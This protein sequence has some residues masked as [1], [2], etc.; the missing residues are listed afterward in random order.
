MSCSPQ[1]GHGGHGHRQKG[2]CRQQG[3]I[4]LH[5]WRLRQA[6]LRRARAPASASPVQQGQASFRWLTAHSLQTANLMAHS[7]LLLLGSCMLGCLQSVAEQAGGGVGGTSAQGLC[8]LACD[9]MPGVKVSAVGPQPLCLAAYLVT[10]WVAVRE[11]FCA[12]ICDATL[13]AAR[14]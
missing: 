10:V 5:G 4:W 13:S 6:H 2:R 14:C 9:V 12:W 1:G 3:P 8:G 7:L 11:S